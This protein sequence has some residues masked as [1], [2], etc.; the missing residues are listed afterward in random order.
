METIGQFG[1]LWQVFSTFGPY[2]LLLIIWW[3]DSVRMRKIMA[4]YRDDMHAILGQCK[5]DMAETRRMYENNVKLVEQ[6]ERLAGDLREVVIMNT[7]AMTSLGD[8]I[9]QNQFCPMQRLEKKR[10]IQ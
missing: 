1:G 8:D 7:T 2:G 9:K 3:S 6:Y 4:E 5:Q 10:R